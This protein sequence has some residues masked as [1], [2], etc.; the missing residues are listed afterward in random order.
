MLDINF[1]RENKKKI[2]TTVKNRG[3]DPKVVDRALKVDETRRQLIGEIEK[4]RQARNKLK[5]DDVE[6]GKKIKEMLRRLEPDLRA[7]EEQCQSVLGQ[8]PNLPADDVPVGK[9]ESD[10]VEIKK[11]G[12]VK[13]FGF[14]V[15]DHLEIGEKLDLIDVKRA[16][17]VSGTRFA[18]L[19][20]EAALLELAL[21]NFSMKFLVKKGFIPIIPPAINKKEVE[22][23]LGYSEHGGWDQM[24]L[25]EKDGL[26]FVAS[27]EHT[28]IPQHLDE[29][30]EEKNLPLRYVGFSSCFRREAGTYGKDTRG[31]FRVHQFDK[32]EMNVITKPDVKV[33]DKE[34]LFMLSCQEE[35]IQT[36]GIPYRVVHCCTGDLPLPNRRMYDLEAW[37][38]GQNK[39]REIQSC[40][41]CTDYQARRLNMRVKTREGNQYAHALNATAIAIGRTIIA[42][43]ENN[44]Q[45]DGSVLIPKV[46]QKYTGF[47]KISPKK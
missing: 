3:L 12:K 14:K 20:N 26:N 25:F 7:V 46:L 4:W 27:S 44:Q 36:L 28:I 35:M 18:Y 41:N 30:L 15:K 1:I 21:I 32:V 31:I 24:Y 9:E 17:K 33:S 42:I 6:E 2:K 43:L 16:A 5:K 47:K 22:W 19:K 39:Y 10:N 11:W 37:F 38:P 40:S 23:G 8:I 29:V 13:K 34:C 45:K